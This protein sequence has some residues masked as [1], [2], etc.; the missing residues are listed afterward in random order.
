[1]LEKTKATI[2]E[3]LTIK[4]SPVSPY[5]GLALPLY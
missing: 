1:M 3:E 5:L 2:A 4:E